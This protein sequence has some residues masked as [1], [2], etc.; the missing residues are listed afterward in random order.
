M[1]AQLPMLSSW[2]AATSH[3]FKT[4]HMTRNQLLRRPCQALCAARRRMGVSP[5]R[6]LGG[7]FCAAQLHHTVHKLHL[8]AFRRAMRAEVVLGV[9]AA[10]FAVAATFSIDGGAHLCTVPSGTLDQQRVELQSTFQ[11]RR[12]RAA[13]A[14]AAPQLQPL[15]CR[16]TNLS[17]PPY[18]LCKAGKQQRTPATPAKSI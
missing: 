4:R 12:R 6:C 7:L 15:C 5:G 2:T 9:I 17:A 8:F 13:A 16:C 18:Y 11:P 3:A 1:P 14:A 10:C